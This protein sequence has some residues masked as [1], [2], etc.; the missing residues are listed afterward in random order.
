MGRRYMKRKKEQQGK[1]LKR[2]IVKNINIK[3]KKIIT[4]QFNINLMLNLKEIKIQIK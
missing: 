2:K 3:N 1:T 4:F